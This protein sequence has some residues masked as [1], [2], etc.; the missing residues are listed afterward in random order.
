MHKRTQGH[1][2]NRKDIDQIMY[3][4]YCIKER[5]HFVVG[6]CTVWSNAVQNKVTIHINTINF[7]MF[8]LAS[9]VFD[10]RSLKLFETILDLKAEISLPYTRMQVY[11]TLNI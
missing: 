11:I 7:S 1:G 6:W 10:I 2:S 3:T 9:F 8:L 5:L 4:V